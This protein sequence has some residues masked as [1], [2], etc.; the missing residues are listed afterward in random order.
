M[1]QAA[2]QEHVAYPR[3]HLE[4]D[5][6]EQKPSHVHEEFLDT[7]L[8]CTT[9][10]H[11]HYL[12]SWPGSHSYH[13]SLETE[14]HSDDPAEGKGGISPKCCD[15][16]S[17]LLTA[18]VTEEVLCVDVTGTDSVGTNPKGKVLLKY[19][20]LLF[21]LWLNQ[22]SLQKNQQIRPLAIY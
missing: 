22:K 9:M 4:K 12:N 17:A 3:A 20:F 10:I 8:G 15:F 7:G 16:R 2:S 11:Q 14:S 5:E 13:S 19:L 6:V 21:I 18:A 1:G